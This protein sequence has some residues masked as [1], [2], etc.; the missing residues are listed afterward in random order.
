MIP[1]DYI[2]Y[3]SFCSQQLPGIAS[4]FWFLEIHQIQEMA[5][6]RVDLSV[7]FKLSQVATY[8]EVRFK[9]LRVRSHARLAAAWL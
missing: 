4:D 7:A 2:V 6:N 3:S 5:W 8:G 9:N 1:L